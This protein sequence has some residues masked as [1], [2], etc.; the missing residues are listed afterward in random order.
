MNRLSRLLMATATCTLACASVGNAQDSTDP[1]METLTVTASLREA[2]EMETAASVSVLDEALIKEAGQQHFESLSQMVPNLNWAGGTSRPRYFQIRGIGERSQYEGAPNPSVGFIVDDI[3]FSGMG[4]VATLFDTR[5]IEVL[6]GPQGTVNG[7]NA[8][9]GLISVRTVDPSDSNE[10]TAETTLGSDAALGAGLAFG[11]PLG[12]SLSYR[13]VAQQYSQDGFRDNAYLGASDTNGRDELTTRGKLYWEVSEDLRVKFT[14]MLVDL[15]NG[16]DAWAIDNSLTTLS[17][18]PGK[19]SQRT[20]AGAMRIEWD[21]SEQVSLL[22]I[23]TLA[24]SDVLFSFDGDWGND[25]SWG[26]NGPYDFFSTTNRQRNSMSQELRLSSRP[27]AELFSGT[28]DWVLGLYAL[29][30]EESND[31]LDTYNGD[32]Y[33]SLYSDYQATN[34]AVF[35]QLDS[36]LAQQWNLAV[37]VRLEQRDATYSDSQGVS[38]E[39][40]DNMPGGHLTLSY[41][42]APLTRL[43][44]TLSRG[45][46]AGG[47]NIN[48]S[49]PAERREFDPEYLWNL[50]FGL[51]TAMPDKGLRGSMAVFYMDRD[52]AQVSTSFQ[53]DPSDPL[54][55][56]FYNDNAA[57]GVNYGLEAEVQWDFA[58]GWTLHGALG[59]LHAEF[60]NYQAG[61]RVLDGREQAHAP[62]WNYNLGL[63][64]HSSEGYYARAD[65]GGK[66]SFYFSDSHEQQSTRYSLLNA[67]LGY[68]GLHWGVQVWARNL[69]DE[70]YQVRGFFFAN[71]PPDW[72]EKLYTRQGDPRQAGVTL[73]YRY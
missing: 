61:T 39:P 32:I 68:Q 58:D 73:S 2:S 38:F 70:E 54:S 63:S 18:K 22:S 44:S 27:G 11:G 51:K 62:S 60:K 31:I 5:Q 56:T 64:Y 41:D 28:T 40:S 53:D 1:R 37:G 4:G 20:A 52:D 72:I 69:L 29:D 48:P 66:D 19:D 34:L 49:I 9:A 15:D 6:R 10:F 26:V 45:Y 14:G 23:S 21:V 35:G 8:L 36:Q 25:D 59:L 67:R 17:D 55:F 50:E 42:M 3:D 57:E 71:E 30:V 24:D 16:Y 46:K 65:L 7:A 12:E 47:F 43:Y 33:R 13:V